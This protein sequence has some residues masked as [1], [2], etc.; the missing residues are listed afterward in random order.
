MKKRNAN[1]FFVAKHDFIALVI[2]VFTHPLS[3]HRIFPHT[4]RVANNDEKV[5][6]SSQGDVCLFGHS[7]YSHSLLHIIL[8]KRRIRP[9]EA[10]YDHFLFYA[11]KI[12]NGTNIAKIG[13]KMTDVRAADSK[14]MTTC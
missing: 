2:P 13:E 5:L 3:P 6:R 9:S 1:Q 7:K 12:M 10:E 8:H 4:F 11:L 14:I